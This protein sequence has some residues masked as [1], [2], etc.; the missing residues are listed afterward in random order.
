MAPAEPPPCASAMDGTD[1]GMASE[2]EFV[3]GGED[4][5][6][7]RFRR[8][9]G[10]QDEHCLRV[11]D[12]RGD[13]LLA[14]SSSPSNSAHRQRVAAKGA[15]GEDVE[16]E[17]AAATWG[18]CPSVAGG[19]RGPILTLNRLGREDVTW[20]TNSSCAATR[21]F[22]GSPPH[23]V[24]DEQA[25]DGGRRRAQRPSRRARALPVKEEQG[26]DRIAAPLSFTSSRGV[27]RGSA[28]GT[29]AMRSMEWSGVSA[30]WR[31]V[32][33]MT[34]GPVACST[35]QAATA[36]ARGAA[37]R[38]ESSSSSNWLGVITSAAGTA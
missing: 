25:I 29:E 10:R 34:L 19:G 2:G 20:G 16:D 38:P 30:V 33:R 22:R 17:I 24:R 9:L 23:G 11:V 1:G 37:A 36:S 3:G 7:A 27:A 28:I 31:L 26:S 12:S 6:R 32:T 13:V 8:I 35:S 4:G 18:G 15:V 5:M 21:S 14:A